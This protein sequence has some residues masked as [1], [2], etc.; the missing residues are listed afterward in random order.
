MTVN[1]VATN[2]LLTASTARGDEDTAIALDMSSALV[3]T[4]GSESLAIT[5]S[6]VPNGARLSAGSENE[7]GTWTL[8]A[9]QLEGLSIR[10]PRDC[11][12]DFTLTVTATST[13]ASG[14]SSRT[15]VSL[16]VTVNAVADAPQ[17]RIDSAAGSEDRAI[18]L[19]ITSTLTDSDGSESLVITI[20]DVPDG[21]VLSAGS[22]N[23]NGSWT[24]S[25]NQLHGLT[26][27]PPAD[28]DADFNLTVTATST[29]TEGEQTSTSYVLPVSVEAVADG[30]IF[31][32]AASG[33][34]DTAIK[35]N[36]AAVLAD[37]DGSETMSAITISG[38][39]T[40]TFL[41]GGT[42]NDDG[43]WTLSTDQLEGLTITPSHN[44]GDSF[45]L[46]VSARTT[47]SASGTGTTTTYV[48]PVS[49]HAVAD[50]P[51][52]S[53]SAVSGNEDTAIALSI[54]TGLT[55]TDGSE[56]LSAVTI[57][58][59][60]D[61]ARLSAGTNNA[62]GSWTVARSALTG[63]TLTPP[64]NSDADFTLH[65]AVTSTDSSGSISTT[66]ADLPVTVNAVAD[67]PTLSATNA[68]GNEDATIALDIRAALSDTDGSETLSAVTISG[69]PTGSVLSAGTNNGNGS[70]TVNAAQ[71]EG[72][73]L[74]PPA[75]SSEDFTLTLAVT[76]QEARG[77]STTSTAQLQVTLTGVADAPTLTVSATSGDEDSAIAL[78]INSALTDSDG[79]ESLCVTISGVPD[80]ATLSAGTDNG[81]GTWTLTAG[82]LTGLTVTPP[83]NAHGAFQLTIT[84]SSTET[85]GD[86]TAVTR[87]ATVTVNPVNDTALITGTTVGTTGEDG[88]TTVSGTLAVTDVDSGEAHFTA[89][90]HQGT[91]GSLAID[92]QGAWTYNLNNDA[93][94]VQSLGDGE[95]AT[96]TITVATA[97]G[98]TQQISITIAGSN[99]A[100]Q[101]TGTTSAEVREDDVT[102][103]SGTLAVTDVD[104]GEAHFTAATHQGTH[105]SL[106]IDEQGAWT[107]NLN[108]D[109]DSVQ[110]LG[111]GETATDTITVA[112]ADG[113]TQ[114]ISITIA[115]SS[116]SLIGTEAGETI[117]GGEGSDTIIAGGG[118]DVLSGNGGNDSLVG[119]AGDDQVFGGS[120]E[121][122]AVFSGESNQYFFQDTGSGL[123]VIDT[124]EGRDGKDMT[125]D[126]E[127]FQFQDITLDQE[128]LLANMDNLNRQTQEY[129]DSS[130]DVFALASEQE[131][132]STDQYLVTD[133]ETE[134]IPAMDAQIEASVETKAEIS[135]AG[136]DVQD[137]VVYEP[138]D[139]SL[140]THHDP[141][142]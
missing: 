50:A 61:G 94:S 78:P 30:V 60:P 54:S 70:W 126:V 56:T 5:I 135:E 2:P 69:V 86:S 18:A 47:E 109:A 113:T 120:G 87:T 97:D 44:S 1:A 125:Y 91:Y 82:Q 55:D 118:D 51:T 104:S 133:T 48:L 111:D 28:S 96:D 101:I 19:D 68:S 12:D 139:S 77:G 37:E 45:N 81:D 75:N 138:D 108:N 17:L 128:F 102:T 106:A 8:S 121:D 13:E 115:G 32:S 100:A 57:S 23:G 98:T 26:I 132:C 117:A 85:D 84:A 58:G 137:S 93:D 73:T 90:T 116:D 124:L 72:L 142:T 107:Y 134:D 4:D 79:S 3:D 42:K 24:L 59:M 53:A 25:P 89:A 122:V 15:T 119:G 38:M 21:A 22:D 9:D 131:A 66:T 7:D 74:T 67:A 10:P 110:G 83:D 88:T 140:T 80:G 114:Q 71:L 49:V 36:L 14:G 27:T 29:E 136:L 33:D 130:P 35:L 11:G 20:N 52:L 40:G 46:I 127:V 129:L 95:T 65:L 62:D 34:E 92:E 6:G 43:T 64:A 112:T 16:P 31:T 99:D 39:P 76:S 103:V 41:S 105:G 63:L 123:E 141:M